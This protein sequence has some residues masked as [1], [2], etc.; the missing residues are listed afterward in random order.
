MNT[1]A[2]CRNY[3]NK[4]CPFSN[5]MCW[6]S[7]VENNDNAEENIKCFIC[8]K[9]FPNKK[10]MMIHRKRDHGS[11]VRDCNLFRQDKCRYNGDSCWFNHSETIMDEDT[12]DDKHKS[13]SV[14]RNAKENQEP[15][16]EKKKE[17]YLEENYQEKKSM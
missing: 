4:T 16:I 8:E 3:A 14:F 1:V 13:A 5:K 10:E 9:V 17:K 6:W 11:F 15:P 12:G 2:F 7:H